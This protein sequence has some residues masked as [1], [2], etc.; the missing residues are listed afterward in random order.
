MEEPLLNHSNNETWF[1]NYIGHNFNSQKAKKAFY[2]RLSLWI[3]IVILIATIN[4]LNNYTK[5]SPECIGDLVFDLSSPINDYFSDN[6]DIKNSFVILSSFF[7]DV[8]LS[9]FMVIFILWGS[10]WRALILASSFYGL[11][12][13]LQAMTVLGFPQGFV[14]GYPG[15][16]SLLITYVRSSDFFYSGHVGMM[17]FT[18]F[19]YRD[20]GYYN[21]KYY[22]LFC[23]VFEACVMVT[24]RCHYSIDIIGAL[25]FC[26]YF[27]ILSGYFAYYADYIGFKQS[28]SSKIISS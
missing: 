2:W 25:L 13:S 15:I 12:G 19:Y 26:H 20:S 22:S 10:S 27:W 8:N 18:Y 17:L 16:Y 28:S 14:W 3:L 5:S 21:L 1:K 23:L 6:P 7:L 4:F 24:V 11:R 9:I